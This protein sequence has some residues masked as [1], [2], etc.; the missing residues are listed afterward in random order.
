MLGV[1]RE[2]AA[3]ANDNVVDVRAILADRDGVQDLLPVAQLPQPRGDSHLAVRADPPRS[4]VG[5]YA[6]RAG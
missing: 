3:G 5:L 4:L 2:K 6:E 1:D